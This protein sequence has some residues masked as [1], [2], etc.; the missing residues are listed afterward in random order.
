V[1]RYPILQRRKFSL[2]ED[3]DDD[4]IPDLSWFGTNGDGGGP[5]WTD[6]EARTLCIQLDASTERGELTGERLFFIYNA[7]FTSHWVNLPP[8]DGGGQWRRAIDTSLA[9]G[10]DL[11]EDG[12]EIVLNPSDHYIANARSMVVLIGKP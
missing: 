9:A 6:P 4:K 12:N 1:R 2:G 5:R 8:L 11:A 10:V 7:D 3:L